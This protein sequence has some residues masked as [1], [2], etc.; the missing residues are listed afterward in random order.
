M[1]T[2]CV[3]KVAAPHECLDQA[4]RLRRPVREHAAATRF[5]HR[6]R[7]RLGTKASR[8][9]SKFLRGQLQAR[10]RLIGD[11]PQNLDRIN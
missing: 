2:V 9:A 8:S 5:H 7:T 3:E 1:S 4:Q 11:E 10:K 6:T